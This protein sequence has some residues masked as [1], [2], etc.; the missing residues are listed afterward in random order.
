MAATSFP[1]KIDAA[2]RFLAAAVSPK[3]AYADGAPTGAQATDP[4]GTPLWRVSVF[5]MDEDAA[6]APEQISVTV[7]A[8]VAP[9]LP[10]LSPV[11]F[12]GL[13]VLMWAGGASL[14]ADSV[15][16]ASSDAPPAPTSAFLSDIEGE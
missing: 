16:V 14:R 3:R 15:E 7:P 1:I 2:Q 6:R 10:A 11:R 9:A 4:A 12:E 5:V 13:R 8:P